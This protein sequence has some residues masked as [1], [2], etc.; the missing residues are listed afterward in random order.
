MRLPS[1][2]GLGVLL[3]ACG[4]S[5]NNATP[6]SKADVAKAVQRLYSADKAAAAGV[7]SSSSSLESRLRS[8]ETKTVKGQSGSARV[9]TVIDQ[10]IGSTVTQKIVYTIVYTGYSSDGLNVFDGTETMTT[11]QE[12]GEGVEQNIQ[13]KGTVTMTGEYSATLV[14][15][16]TLSQ[17]VHGDKVEMKLTGTTDASGTDFSFSNESFDVDLSVE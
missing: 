2:L 1:I 11:T 4:G 12:V 13:L 16:V 17:S 5:G 6:S 14:H 9:T 10:E 3:V 7:D 15:D 8:E